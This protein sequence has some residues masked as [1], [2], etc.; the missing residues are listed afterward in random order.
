VVDTGSND[1]AAIRTKTLPSGQPGLT[2]P[3]PPT[4]LI[5]VGSRPRD[6]AIKV[7]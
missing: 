6:L 3:R 7:F 2:P 5:N 4:A 1:L